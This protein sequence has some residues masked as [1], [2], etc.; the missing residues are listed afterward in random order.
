MSRSNRTLI[1][2]RKKLTILL[3]GSGN[4][5]VNTEASRAEC[6]AEYDPSIF[7]DSCKKHWTKWMAT[8]LAER[9]RVL[10]IVGQYP[11]PVQVGELMDIERFHVKMEQ[12]IYTHLC[13]RKLQRPP[14]IWK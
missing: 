6:L 4:R 1:K 2:R 7:V 9:E 11:D 3:D 13:V 12:V 10:A 8:M 5:V 14:S